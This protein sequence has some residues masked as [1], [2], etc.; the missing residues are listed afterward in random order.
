MELKNT[1]C[2]NSESW[3]ILFI[4]QHKIHVNKIWEG[5]K[6]YVLQF[7]HL[8]DVLFWIIGSILIMMVCEVD[9]ILQV[10]YVAN[11]IVTLSMNT[12]LKI[13]VELPVLNFQ[14]LDDKKIAIYLFMIVVHCSITFNSNRSSSFMLF[15]LI[16]RQ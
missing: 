4:I 2:F 16:N 5:Y 6:D 9:Y 10:F 12:I 15:V 11:I 14:L 3:N 7:V 8:K 13:Y 1:I